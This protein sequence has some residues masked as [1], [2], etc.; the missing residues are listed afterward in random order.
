MLFKADSNTIPWD[1]TPGDIRRLDIYY[2]RS[3][4]TP[5][6]RNGYARPAPHSHAI[7]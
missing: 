7:S 3:G 5:R 6:P 2:D 1:F 4:F